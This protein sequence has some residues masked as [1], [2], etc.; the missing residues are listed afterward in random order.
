[1]L[2]AAVDVI[3]QHRPDVMLVHFPSVD[4]VGHAKGWATP[5]QVK[6]IEQA[7]AAV[8][9][10]LATLDEMKLTD[11]TFVIITADH[12]GAGKN[13]G[14]D[15]PRSRHI[16]W[17]AVGPGVRAGIDLTIYPKL[18][19]NTEDT[20]ATTCWLMGIP[21]TVPDMDGVPVKLILEQKEVELLHAAPAKAPEAW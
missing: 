14:P 15:D 6:A 8:G 13:H 10:L 4:A 2:K 16:P 12:G 21:P 11:S 7:D 1:V 3:R 5:E 20:F 9:T 18:T 17:I 19:I